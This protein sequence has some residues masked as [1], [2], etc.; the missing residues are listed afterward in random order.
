MPRPSRRAV[1][2]SALLGAVG[3]TMGAAADPYVFAAGAEDARDADIGY[4]AGTGGTALRAGRHEVVWSVPTTA[5]LVAVTFD[6]GPH[7]DYTPR[8]LAA[9]QKARV[10]AT[11]NVMGVQARRYPSLLAEVVAE[12]HEIGNHTHTHADLTTLDRARTTAEIRDAQ[13]ELQQLVQQQVRLFRPPRGELT[14]FGLRVAAE[15]QLDVVMWSLDRG[16]SGVG[17]AQQVAQHIGGS[18]RRGDI[19]AL[20]DGLGHAGL[21][22]AS[23]TARLLARRR[24]VEV[25]A[26]PRALELVAANGLRVVPVSTLLRS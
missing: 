22:P 9:L 3:I 20:H 10:T 14:G 8:I 13:D 23:P 21:H 16:P 7:P 6:D 12:G 11:F 25:H 17:T 1:I 4:A 2:G 15:L 26:L 18:A 5:P 19:I 24:N